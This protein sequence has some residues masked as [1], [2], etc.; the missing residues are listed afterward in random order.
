MSDMQM[1]RLEDAPRRGL[2]ACLAAVLL[3][4]GLVALTAGCGFHPRGSAALPPSMAITFI[5]SGQ[6]LFLAG[7]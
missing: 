6:P 4:V 3:L 5:K 2:F 1:M 7:G